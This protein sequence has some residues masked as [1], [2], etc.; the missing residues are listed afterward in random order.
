MQAVTL[1]NLLQFDLLYK[2]TF[3]NS[4]GSKTKNVI[5]HFSSFSLYLDLLVQKN[6]YDFCISQEFN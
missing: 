2:P 6:V 4:Y 5:F 3:L 1:N